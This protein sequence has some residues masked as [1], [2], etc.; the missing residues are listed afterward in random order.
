MKAIPFSTTRKLLAISISIA[1]STVTHAEEANIKEEKVEQIQVT[2][3]YI[4]RVAADAAEPVQ[5]LDHNYIQSTGATTISELIGKLAISSGAENQADSF[6]QAAT[7]GTG[8]VNLRGLGLSSTLVL[9][10]G[11]RQTISGALTNDGSVFVDTSHIPIDAIEQVEVLKE[12]AASTYGSDAIAGV[13]NFILRKD[14]EGLEFNASISKAAN[15]SQKDTD[16]G[17]LWG[18]EFENTFVNISGHYLDRT[19]LT[20]ADRPELGDIA[21]SGLGNSFLLLNTT[22]IEV[23]DGLYAGTYAPFEKVPDPRCL[24]D[25]LGMLIPEANGASCGFNFGPLYNLVNTETRAQLYSNVNHYFDNGNE[26]LV[27]ISWSSNEVKDNPQSPSYPDLTFPYI[28][29]SL[30]CWCCLVR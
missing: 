5:V 22:P 23:V 30:W 7:Q 26:L 25:S 3:S 2:G 14:F 6:S 15:S 24:D 28:G 20:I 1:L 19:P 12:G 13:V 8:N 4:K 9:I 29:K 16:I 27:D 18:A 21:Y 11:R 10:N 17:F